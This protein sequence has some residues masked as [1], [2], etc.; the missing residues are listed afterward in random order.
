LIIE[1]DGSG[2][3]VSREDME[4]AKLQGVPP[5][6]ITIVLIID[7][8]CSGTVASREDMETAKLQGLPPGS[9]IIIS[10]IEHDCSGTFASREDMET[11]KIQ[12]LPP[13]SITILEVFKLGRVNSSQVASQCVTIPSFPRFLLVISHLPASCSVFSAVTS[14]QLLPLPLGDSVLRF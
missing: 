14:L 5:G 12:G 4:T 11:T 1:H 8:D 7:H 2:T 3:V 10:I 9:I 13:G 6:S